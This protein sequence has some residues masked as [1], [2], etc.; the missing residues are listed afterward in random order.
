MIP[1][2]H[3]LFAVAWEKK[4][5]ISESFSQGRSKMSAARDIICEYIGNSR[6]RL[7]EPRKIYQKRPDIWV[8]RSC[9]SFSASSSYLP[10]FF[11][12]PPS[13]DIS[14]SYPLLLIHYGKEKRKGRG[15]EALSSSESLFCGISGSFNVHED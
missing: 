2:T 7:K 5:N 6:Q 8:H 3:M 4:R 11:P 15:Q 13:H 14:R 10:L 12:F 1:S 9:K